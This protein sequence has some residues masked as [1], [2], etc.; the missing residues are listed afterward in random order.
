MNNTALLG[1]PLLIFAEVLS[2]SV[3]FGLGST[4]AG[5]ESFFES[6]SPDIL[7][8]C[9]TNLMRLNWFWRFLCEGL[10]SFHLKGFCYLYTWPCSLYEGV[11]FFYTWLA[12]WKHWGLVFM[13][14]TGFISSSLLLFPSSITILFFVLSCD[15]VS[16][17][18][19]KVLLISPLQMDL[20][21]KTFM[22]MVEL[23]DS[24]KSVRMFLSQTTFL[25]SLASLLESLNVILKI[26]W[27]KQL[28]KE[29]AD[30]LSYKH[31]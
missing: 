26:S 27:N 6:N 5:F 12:T 17:C 4:F 9:V 10:S 2:S 22:S 1:L 3:I 16:S 24:G 18:K 30:P 13:S 19:D 15:T 25:R 20:S 14:L 8:F 23:S 29:G 28:S 21:L 11:T 31:L 7:A